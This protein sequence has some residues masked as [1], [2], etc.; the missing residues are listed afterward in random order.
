MISRL[1]LFVLLLTAAV[2]P[3]AAASYYTSK[4]PDPAAVVV[5]PGRDGVHGDGVA[6][7]TEALQRAIDAVQS[8]RGQ[9][10]VLVAEGRY[11]LTGT[12][13][14]WPAIRVIGYGTRRPALVLGASTPGFSDPSAPRYMLFFAGR[15]PSDGSQP[16]DANPG[17]FYSALSNV[18]LEIGESNPGAVGVRARYAQHCFTSHVEFRI[19]SGLAGIHE[20][21]N[22]AEDVRFVGGDYGIWTSTPSPSWQYTLL[23]ATF[24]G[25]RKAAIRDRAAA[26][27][28]IRPTFRR[29]PTAVEMEDGAPD[30]LWL[31]DAWLE[32]V[33]GPALIV[34]RE[35]SARTQVNVRRAVCRRVPVFAAFRESGR[36]VAGRGESYVV[37]AFSHGLHFD[38]LEAA[39]T[40][41]TVFEAESVR[42]V[43]APA[44]SDL[45]PIPPV[46][47]W[48]DARTFGARG[49]GATDDT[50]ALRRAIASSRTVFLP[51][52]TY[53]VSDTL[54][55][56]PDSVLVALHPSATQLVIPDR[57]AAFQAPGGPKALIEA[58]AGGSTVVIGVGL[59]TNGINPRAVGALWMAGERS[60][61]NDVRF[62]GGHGTVG[63]DGKRENPYN[64]AHTADPD[65]NRR[66]D[67]QY[68]SLWVTRGGGGTFFDLWTPSTFAQSGMLVT[69]TSTPGRVYHMSA[70]HHVRHEVQLHGVEHW[71]L[72]AL[73][74][75]AERGESGFAVPLEI[76]DSRDILISNLHAYRVISSDQP[77]P[78]TVTVSG[79][80]DIRFR[81]VHVYS[82]SK[83]SYDSA[84]FDVDRGIEL[85][86]R[87]FAWL[88]V[89]GS[90]PRPEVAS[91]ARAAHAAD[92][93][94]L[95]GGFHNASSAAADERGVHFVDARWQRIY[96][97]D[98]KERRL[99]VVSDAPIQPV[100]VTLDRSGDLLVV[101]YAGAGTVYSLPANGTGTPVVLASKPASE[102]SG[103]WFV[104]PVSDWRLLSASGDT[105][106]GRTHHYSA[107]DGATVVSATT[108]FV[109]GQLSWGVK[110]ADLVRSFGLQVAR[111]AERVYLSSE[112]DA[113]TWSAVVGTDGSLSDV[114]PFVEQGAEALAQDRETGLVY[115]AAGDIHV[116]DPKG[117]LV[118]TIEVPER[119]TSLAFGDSDGRTLYIT[120]R[121][122]LY[123]LRVR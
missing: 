110:S 29:V 35:A 112:A 37:G 91:G 77:F 76:R 98:A 117:T 26:L 93:Q 23:D 105:L 32:D 100:N 7:D 62:L 21:G 6:D 22:A 34:S 120:S 75:E 80:R 85:R 47:S 20:G 36:T 18:D 3:A 113:A 90:A 5:E 69:D 57:T 19:G 116:Y 106:P 65:L 14:V 54:V 123:A 11:R 118:R 48:A 101:S 111:A 122:S 44:A 60:M 99:V 83:V 88:D 102:L 12:V 115:L 40:T 70:E 119:P 81:G 78:W 39:G 38:H 67:S 74:T 114:K 59:Y 42:Q 55:L 41:K 16:P 33:S 25:Q 24:E 71:E 103:A 53:I 121:H 66:W 27:T 72:H 8:A 104:L 31:Q 10:V 107:P 84:V 109:E 51:T 68:P 87:E 28:L 50:E 79:S 64:N 108:G 9:G 86:Q 96:R 56:R 95:A 49:D 1:G 52:G 30:N 13:Y 92:L 94:R 61:M 97:W 89:P 4:P 45:A 73:Q 46:E 63:I 43:P 82:N 2:R 17:T 58:P 15:R